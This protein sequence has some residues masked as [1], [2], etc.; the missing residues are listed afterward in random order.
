MRVTW[1]TCSA[2]GEPEVADRDR[3]E[4]AQLDAAVATVTGAV[5][6]GHAVP[7]K[8]GAAFQQQRLVGLDG[9]QV[10]GLLAGHQEGG[11]VGVGVQGV[12]GHDHPGKVQAGQQRDEGR[13][14]AGGAVDGAL[15]Q[16]RAGGVVHAGQQVDLPAVAGTAGAAQGLAVDRDRPPRTSIGAGTGTVVGSQPGA[17]HPGQRHRV[18]AGQG[19]AEG[20]LGRHHPGAGV[21]PPGAERGPHRLRVSAAHSAIAASDRA[22]ASTAAAARA[23]RGWWPGRRAEWAPRPTGAGRRGRGGPG[24]LGL[25][26]DGSAGTGVHRDH[27]GVVAA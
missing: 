27:E 13:H 19:P 7:S 2:C 26:M 22:P 1:I 20:G 6:D 18:H 9:E 25:G 12:G 24:R 5:Q 21:G 4:G 10:V 17:K 3:L 23:R 15:G 14:L 11:G 16:H 8:A